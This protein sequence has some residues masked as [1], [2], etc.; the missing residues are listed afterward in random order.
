L[1][2]IIQIKIYKFASDLEWR[3]FSDDVSL[4]DLIEYPQPFPSNHQSAMSEG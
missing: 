1:S 4:M 3:C 2:I